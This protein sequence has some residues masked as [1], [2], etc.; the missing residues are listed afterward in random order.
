LYLGTSEPTDYDNYSQYVKALEYAIYSYAL[1]L[2]PSEVDVTYHTSGENAY[3]VTINHMTVDEALDNIKTLFNKVGSY[4]G[5]TNRQTEKLKTWVFENIIGY[6][7]QD[8]FNWYSEVIEKTDRNG[9]ITYEFKTKDNSKSDNLGRNYQEA[10][11]AI[12]DGVCSQVT[13]GNADGDGNGYIDDE[14]LASEIMEYAGDMFRVSDDD[15]FSHDP[16]ASK[17]YLKPMEYQSVTLMLKGDSILSELWIALK[18]DADNDGT[19]EGIW[20]TS[21][22]I[23]IIVE[24]N[25]F[26]HEDQ[27]MFTIGKEQARVYDGPFDPDHENAPDDMYEDRGNVC[28]WD[29]AATCQDPDLLKHL[30]KDE[31]LMIGKFNTEI[32]DKA[33]MTDV[34]LV[35]KY[36]FAPLISNNPLVLTGTSPARRYYQLLEPSADENLDGK[37]YITGRLNPEKF[38]G[39]DGCDYLEITYKVLKNH[40]TDTSKNYKFYTGISY[41]Y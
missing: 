15:N 29:F 37:T 33:L 10:V 4:V 41:M 7:A 28:F 22:Y 21:K 14:F 17:F 35:G 11:N 34:G 8:D 6:S 38:K 40:A 3:T 31:D 9:N 19:E 30:D 39:A 12:I 16:N 24:L 18:Y 36:K 25:Y 23:D 1:D 27:K 20:D 13:I 32:G 26:S 2:E 5:L